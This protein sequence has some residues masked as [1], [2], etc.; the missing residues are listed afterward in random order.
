MS[1]FGKLIEVRST[2][3]PRESADNEL[4][5]SDTM[6]GHALARYIGRRLPEFGMSVARYVPEDW[7]WY[8]EID[9]DGFPLWYGV[10][11]TDEHEFV[12]QIHPE[13]PTIRRWFKKVDVSDKTTALQ[14]AIF[15]V[16][17]NPSDREIKARW[18]AK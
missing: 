6:F 18:V 5:N 16:L 11:N 17:S 3:F 15:S 4:V 9:N 8:C 13:K 7:G 12:I 14:Q 1:H 10:S 2:A